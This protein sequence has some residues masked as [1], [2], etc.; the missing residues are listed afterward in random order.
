MGFFS[1]KT[2]KSSSIKRTQGQ[3]VECSKC[4]CQLEPIGNMFD[5]FQGGVVTTDGATRAD[6]DQ[7]SGWLCTNCSKVY[8]W[9]CE[10]AHFGVP[11]CPDCGKTF[12]AAASMFLK[13]I[14][15]L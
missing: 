11:K 9:S 5:S 12:L 8:C 7:W 6:L 2:D 4:G 13:Q 1:K 10:P 14:G 15:K 3:I